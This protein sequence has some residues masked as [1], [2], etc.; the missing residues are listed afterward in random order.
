MNLRHGL[1]LL[2][3]ALGLLLPAAGQAA[4]V[5]PG[6]GPL[7]VGPLDSVSPKTQSST[8]PAGKVLT[9]A[10]GNVATGFGEVVFDDLTPSADLKTSTVKGV[11]DQNGLAAGWAAVSQPVCAY[12]LGGMQRV[13]AT[14]ALNSSNKSVTVTCPAGKRVVGGGSDINAGNGQV[15]VD[16][17]RPSADLTSITVQALEDQDGHSGPWNVTAYAVC[18]TAPQGLERVSVTSALD[19]TGE[20]TVEAPCPAGKRVLGV[21]SDINAGV[22]SGAADLGNGPDFG[23]TGRVTADEDEDGQSGPWSV[24]AFAI[25]AFDAHRVSAT[26]VRDSSFT[27]EVT[28]NCDTGSSS[29]VGAEITGGSA[30]LG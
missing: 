26:S 10:G 14:S 17:F 12:P 25:C 13:G 21:G 7:A 27:K 6:P 15:G 20:K 28:V 29:G 11:E 5:D 23:L 8:C 4:V 1:A 9:S 19:S 24:T 2:V 16:D 22:R 30:R 18:A 3:L